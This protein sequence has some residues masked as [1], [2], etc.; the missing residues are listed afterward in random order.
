MIN[1][2]RYVILSL[3]LHLFFA[4]IMK[5]HGIFLEAGFT[6]KDSDKSKKA[7]QFKQQFEGLLDHAVRLSNGIVSSDFL[8]SGEMI[9]DYTL[10]SEQKTENFTGI[11]INGNITMMQA[12][13]H[14]GTNPNITPDMY[15][16][17]KQLN[18]NAR[19]LIDAFIN[20]K[21]MVLNEV[22]TCN[23]ATSNY[24]L[25]IQHLIHEAHMY[26]TQLM[27]LE[28]GE[29]IDKPDASQTESFWDEIM[30][31]HALFIRGMLDP[32]ENDLIN[33]ANDFANEYRQL[34][35]KMDQAADT[36][37]NNITSD[38]LAETVKFRDFK[39]A[40]VKGINECKIRS[41]IQPLLADHV[42]REANHYIRMLKMID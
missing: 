31:E 28:S 41:I 4:R 22:L 11:A 36:M 24:P 21:A 38:T 14:S 32:T 40:G 8:T 27:R 20:F 3:E 1:E 17:V 7:D 18:I 26:S 42:L 6:P 10:G 12:Q 9:T 29:D 33:T 13:L 35:A 2:Q 25:M 23:I 16:S 39:E 34:L 19:M 30:L 15:L 5:E 37:I